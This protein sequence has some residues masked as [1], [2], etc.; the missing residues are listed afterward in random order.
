MSPDELA[1]LDEQRELRHRKLDGRRR[2]SSTIV[3]QLCE[4]TFFEPLLEDAKSG[5][6]PQE[7]LRPR[8]R[9]VY[10]EK[11]VAREHVARELAGN[12]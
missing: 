9:A 12:Q 6:V 11:A 2:H 8:T 3:P 7:H 10:E 5:A 4:T 1:A